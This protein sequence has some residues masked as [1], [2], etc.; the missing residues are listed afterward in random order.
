M[1]DGTT[2]V[3]SVVVRREGAGSAVAALG[4]LLLLACNEPRS[5]APN[6]RA[7]D[8]PGIQR[9]PGPATQT[10]SLHYRLSLRDGQQ[11][12]EMMVTF[13]NPTADTVYFIH[14]NGATPVQLQVPLEEPW[15]SVWT[16][17]QDACFSPPI[18]V[19]PSDSLR[20]RV[21]LFDGFKP[22]DSQMPLP[23]VP[24]T[25]RLVWAGL[26]RKSTSSAPVGDPLP[27][28]QRTSNPFLLSGGR[29]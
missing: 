25:Y 18:A 8:T 24:A 21:L 28:E 2:L 5:D 16:S 3:G 26:V 20:R 11:V 13:R 22:G 7:P 10:D 19:P 12:A 14:C 29:P 6:G 9:D 4:C 17:E 27:L 1:I 15:V 23:V